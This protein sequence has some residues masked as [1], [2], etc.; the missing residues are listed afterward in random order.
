MNLVSARRL[1][2]AL[3]LLS[4]SWAAGSRSDVSPHVDYPELASFRASVGDHVVPVTI[5]LREPRGQQALPGISNLDQLAAARS[6]R[7]AQQEAL[8]GALPGRG[9][10][11]LPATVTA[12]QADGSVRTIALR[13]RGL[14][15]TIG[16]Y[17]AHA[18]IAKLRAQPEVRAVR[19]DAPVRLYLNK[20]VDYTLGSA[21]EPAARR[22]AIYGTN[23]ELDP[24]GSPNHPETPPST[25]IDGLEGQGIIVSIIDS[26][27]DWRH[28][29]F[30]GTGLTSPTP[31]VGGSAAS[32]AD[33][34]KLTYYYNLSGG[35]PDDDF[36]HGT[37]VAST[38]I[39]YRVDGDTPANPGFGTGR[40]GTGIGPTIDGA[41][42]HGLAPAAPM[43][44]YKM[45]NIAGNCTAA[46][47]VEFAIEDSVSPTTLLPETGDDTGIAKPIADVIS[48]SLGATG[49]DAL[50]SSSVASNNAA[51]AGAIVVAAAGNS[52]PGSST[53]GSPCTGAMVICVAASL[54]PGSIA[55]LDVLAAGSIPTET[56]AG[57]TPS[58]G[59]TA[60][61]A[62]ETGDASTANAA[63]ATERQAIKGFDTAGGGALPGGSV[64]AHYVF[65]DMRP[66][67]GNTPPLTATNR[68]VLV[69]GTGAF[70]TI[71]NSLAPVM[72][73]AILIITAV[74]SATAV[75]VIGGIPTYT[76]NPADAD[77]LIDLMRTGDDDTVNVPHGTVS[78]LPLRVSAAATLES[79]Q[80]AL[81][82][83]SSRGP[84]SFAGSDFRTIK[85]DIAAP[86]V[87]VVAATTPEGNP[88]A[89]IGMANPSGYT[90]ASG[91]SMATPHVS[92][93]MALIRQHLRKNL[94][95]D[96]TDLDDPEYRTKRYDTAMVARALAQNTATSLRNGR[97]VAGASDVLSINDIG[98]GLIDVQ[99]AID[100]KA[101]MVA[102][103]RL[104]VGEFTPPTLN[105][106]TLNADNTL[107]VLLPSYSFGPVPVA[108][109]PGVIS[110][111]VKVLLRD[112]TAGG[113]GGTYQL[114]AQG[115]RNTD[116]GVA[117][118]FED[119]AGNAI[120]SVNVPNSGIAEFQVRVAVDGTQYILADTDILWYVTAT[121]AATSRTLRMPFYLRAVQYVTA[122]IT[123]APVQNEPTAVTTPGT[124][125]ACSTDADGD[126]TVNFTYT[127]PTNGA[128]PIGFR[129]QE[130][131]GFTPLF[132]DLAD[133]P[134]VAGANSLW[135]G[136]EEWTSQVNP[137]TG[138]PAYFAPDVSDQNETLTMNDAI[139]LPASASLLI[140]TYV[141]T[142][143]DF[144][145][146]V[147]ELVVGGATVELGRYSGSFSGTLQFDLKAFAGEAVKVQLRMT[148][149]QL[150]PGVGW[151]V[152]N[153]RIIGDDFTTIGEP[154]AA[155]TS[156]AVP[157]RAGGTRHYRVAA[158]FADPVGTLAGPYSNTKC[159]TVELPNN[160]PVVDAGAGF[161]MDEGATRS[162]AGTATDADGDT[163]TYT[164]TQEAGPAVSNFTGTDTLTPSFTAP[165]VGADTVLTFML[166][167]NDGQ[168]AP[169]TDTVQVTVHDLNAGGGSSSTIGNNSVGGALPWLSLLV[170]GLAGVRRRKL[171]A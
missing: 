168:N 165:Q 136:S 118:T 78:E 74:E 20:S 30:G 143:L 81:A 37:H 93:A 147:V 21:F 62:E 2:V 114:S 88:S 151:Y 109:S 163:L 19:V 115:N 59:A 162:L 142:E 110:K 84:N 106:P 99:A 76:I 132:T 41:T 61:P 24:A 38:S 39:G 153:I 87:G 98:S 3:V 10:R 119:L 111:T 91:T 117:I 28:P 31:R 155:A 8:L 101:I 6:R 33:H 18:D 170:L 92:G 4:L 123:A 43:I 130:G 138:N 63:H 1:S 139:T 67:Q 121:H 73:A 70:A 14:S 133:E 161:T 167:V 50:E 134:L 54:D 157:D 71:A 96:T 104:R 116:R 135:T 82:G 22:L 86:G 34:T 85:P 36:G 12:K 154:A 69:I 122:L 120:T 146:A 112:I 5:E 158:L 15:N 48:M 144:D 40:D 52:G 64:S 47:G 45:C 49:G 25:T 26:G 103:T 128:T 159:V 16:A 145:F 75:S 66:D 27:I 55:A 108:N 9:I 32:A 169:V 166:T 89:G 79:F 7:A 17:V 107:D 105:P 164:W 44:G 29:M 149:D 148:A 60:G 129:V 68:I 53:V 65:A 152:E 83:F 131:T 141:E 94:G 11:L 80:G 150:V 102:P 56:A 97:G 126:Y 100:A 113:G 95:F 77:Y 42:L 156:H 51:L 13:N 124:D 57:K 46:G 137:D 171:H 35:E 160:L 140:D 23:E 90:S 72:P 58:E 125:P 127:A